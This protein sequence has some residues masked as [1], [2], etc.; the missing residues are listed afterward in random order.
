[1]AQPGQGIQ[2]FMGTARR[3]RGRPSNGARHGQSG[4]APREE[5]WTFDNS[6]GELDGV[7]GDNVYSDISPENRNVRGRNTTNDQ[8]GTGGPLT[9]KKLQ[10][11]TLQQTQIL[12]GFFAIC[13]HP[14]EHQR[15]ELSETTGLSAKQVKFWFQN[16]LTQ[17]KNLNAKEENYRLKVERAM[18][19]AENERLKQAE[20]TTFC[21]SCD[22][23]LH[24]QLSPNMQRLKE[25][26]EW[27]KLE[28]SQ[29]HAE[30]L[31]TLRQSFQLASSAG[32][33]VGRQNDTR[34]ILELAQDAMREFVILS[35][36]HGPLWLP[37]PGGSFE[38]LN[39]MAY[40]QKFGGKNNADITGI[41]TEATRADAVVMMGAKHIMDYLMDSDCYASLCPGIVSSAKMI[42][43]YEW[44]TNAGY[45]G[46]MRLMA[47]E[48]VFPSPLV[49][50]RKCTFV[51]FC[52]T[53]QNGTMLVVDVSLDGGNG[54]F[55]K[56]R[57]M[58]SGVLIQPLERSSCKVITIEHVLVDDTG[59]HK[60]YQPC[61][62]G[63]MFGARRWVTSIARQCGRLRAIFH[64]TGS[65]L[66]ANSK[67]R[68]TL[69]KLADDLLVSYSN[70]VAA[71]PEDVW[72]IVHSAGM[73]Q[74]IKVSYRRND[75]RSN[76]AVVSV[77]TSFQL[78][79]PLRVTF[80]LLRNNIVRPKWDVLVNDGVVREEVC[81]SGGVEADDAV[82]ILHVKNAAGNKEDITILQNSCYDV[83][84]SFIVYSPI[85]T[86]L[87]NKIMSPG[88][89][90]ESNVSIYP[91]G[92]SL[93]P[94]SESAQ[95]GVGL[96]EN[97]ETLVT[98]GF[99]ILL[100]LAH[101]T[102]LYPRSVTAASTLMS[103]Y[104]E[105]IK[106]SLIDSHPILYRSN[107]YPGPI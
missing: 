66:R 99:Q 16:K 76:T 29:L 88:G 45:D 92:F 47:T 60:L 10:R 41:K 89:M 57:K 62:S 72:A 28:I 81:V 44:P 101:G 53:L 96:G 40:D 31:P 3:G 37:V 93:L 36:S 12:E 50:S 86:Q 64:V 97:G 42:K 56:C 105:T 4:Q 52:R 95:G 46:A 85:D 22:P 106:K 90:E 104:M 67:G 61:L 14:T 25:Q 73:D 9:G 55:L 21:A 43:A 70:G 34:V 5:Q 30:T 49:P 100:K 83:S 2:S 13:A 32:N 75:D 54:T 102:G 68:K 94:V 87:M 78:P 58:P 6:S 17:V 7:Y 23:S 27:L 26:N 80:D 77:S 8:G 11:L 24:I 69:M 51:R 98:V 33:V 71:I 19:R 48:T 63:L 84:G 74:D 35:E 1:M 39:K 18:L 15:G 59:V 103:E 38:V 107:Q 20:R 79:M 65:A 82:S 91:T